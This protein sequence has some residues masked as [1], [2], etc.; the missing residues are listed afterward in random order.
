LK[1][2]KSISNVYQCKFTGF[3]LS[4]SNRKTINFQH[5]VY[6]KIQAVFFDRCSGTVDFIPDTIF[7]VF[8][9]L[10]GL[11]VKNSKLPHVKIGLFPRSF[12]PLQYLDISLNGIQSIK[13]LAFRELTNLKLI[14][15]AQ[16][17]IEALPYNIFKYNSRL[18]HID[19]A[20]NKI[21]IINPLLFQNLRY[22]ETFTINE[23]QCADTNLVF[24]TYGVN[25][26][27]DFVEFNRT[28]KNCH[29]NCAN[30]TFCSAQTKV[31]EE[32]MEQ[33]D[34]NFEKLSGILENFKVH[35]FKDF[36]KQFL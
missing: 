34:G 35:A 7:Q 26:D 5:V 14:S 24:C 4:A 28:L 6:Y 1:S 27:P 29:E 23:N 3:D 11:S 17:E 31:S 22:M 25:C 33:I 9:E 8:S 20:G 2:W 15:L 13:Y 32:L 12:N 36:W 21:K 19:L 18:A 10:D 16:N 30:D